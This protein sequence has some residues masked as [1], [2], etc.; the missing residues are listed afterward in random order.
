VDWGYFDGFVPVYLWV[1]KETIVQSS[2]SILVF[3]GFE[4]SDW[5]I[6]DQPNLFS[7][8][9]NPSRRASFS[10]IWFSLG[11][12]SLFLFRSDPRAMQRRPQDFCLGDQ[13]F[14]VHFHRAFS[15]L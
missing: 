8:R 13:T 4:F 2:A 14:S 9:G 3:V 15:A 7:R 12:L 6:F 1:V 10:L 5:S 11:T